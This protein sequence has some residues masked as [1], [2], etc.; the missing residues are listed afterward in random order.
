M[1]APCTRLLGETELMAGAAV[2]T[3]V[4]LKG[5]AALPLA[6]VT[7]TMPEPVA[8]VV[9]TLTGRL[10]DV[11]VAVTVP[12]VIPALLKLTLAPVR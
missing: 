7:V 12:A 1:A 9:A 6:V 4:T 5:A 2:A 3:A 10:I 11:A 8:A